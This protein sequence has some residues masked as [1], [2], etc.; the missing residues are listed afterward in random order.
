M[1]RLSNDSEQQ[2]ASVNPDELRIKVYLPDDGFTLN[3]SATTFDVQILAG[4][5]TQ[6]SPF[7]LEQEG[8]SQEAASSGLFSGPH[9]QWVYVLR[10]T[11]ASRPRF[12]ALQRFVAPRKAEHIELKISFAVLAAPKDEFP[13]SVDLQM[14][15]AE[16]YFPLLKDASLR[17]GTKKFTTW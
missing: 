10:L 7:A 13:V 16:G 3:P 6:S 9:K 14:V 1:Y 15:R 2:F 8:V 4:G 5:A 11:D 17:I 12:V